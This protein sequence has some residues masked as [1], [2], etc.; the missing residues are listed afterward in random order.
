MIL[1][2]KGGRNGGARTYC[3]P[4]DTNVYPYNIDG[5]DWTMPCICYKC[6]R[7]PLVDGIRQ[8]FMHKVRACLSSE[9]LRFVVN[10]GEL[11]AH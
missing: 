11:S 9:V 8:I 4:F 7:S 3:P 1:G 10:V 5:G 6:E 2:V